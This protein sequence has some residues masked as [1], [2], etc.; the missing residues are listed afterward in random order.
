MNQNIELFQ[1]S[2]ATEVD[3]DRAQE[4]ESP[5]AKE[6]CEEDKRN[7]VIALDLGQGLVLVGHV[8]E[9]ER[10]RDHKDRGRDEESRRRQCDRHLFVQG[11]TSFRVEVPIQNIFTWGPATNSLAGDFQWNLSLWEPRQTTSTRL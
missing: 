10:P 6:N 11:P 4:P 9:E 7:L 2:I 3:K 5:D 8:C 1:S